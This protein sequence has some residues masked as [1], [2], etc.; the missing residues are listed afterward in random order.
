MKKLNFLPDQYLKDSNMT[1]KHNY[2]G[3]QFSDYK[4]IFKKIGKIVKQNDFTLGTEVDI[5]ENNI[6]KL[7]NAKYVVAVG[8]GTDALMLS[9]KAA[10]V[11]PGSEVITTSFTF[12]ATIGAIVTLGAKPIYVDIRD[13][14]NIDPTKIEKKNNKKNQSYFA[15]SLVR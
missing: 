14:F 12:Y 13:D 11:N 4:K 10:G 8:S 7:L 6:S 15:S 3:K 9:L 1:S 5:F 2:L